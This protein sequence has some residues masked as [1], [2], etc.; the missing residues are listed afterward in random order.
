MVRPADDLVGERGDAAQLHDDR[1]RQ[2]EDHVI[3]GTGQPDHDVVL[4]RRQDVATGA[5]ERLVEPSDPGGRDV[6]RDG[7]PQLGPEAGDEVDAADRRPRLAQRR[8][9]ERRR[10]AVG[11]G[12][13]SNS[14]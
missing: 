9:V 2:V 10:R 7:C 12:T 8:D 11:A 5:D 4:R 1:P 13:R 3:G 6:G 14:R